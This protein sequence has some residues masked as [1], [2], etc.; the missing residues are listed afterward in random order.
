LNRLI[1][2]DSDLLRQA[3]IGRLQPKRVETAPPIYTYTND[4][5]WQPKTV[6]GQI[7]AEL[8]IQVYDCR[9]QPSVTLPDAIEKF[10]SILADRKE[11]FSKKITLCVDP[12]VDA[13]YESS[14]S[15]YE[16]SDSPYESSDSPYES[17][18]SPYE[19]SDSPYE[20]SDSPYESSD[21]P[22]AVDPSI[23]SN[24]LA[25]QLALERIGFNWLQQARSDLN[26]A[27]VTVLILDTLPV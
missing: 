21:S 5:T 17:S 13:P 18:D 2:R 7:D 14:D 12:T 24:T 15:P 20:S 3:G 9:L 11:E 4:N 23:A 26:G 8:S 16:S 6:S 1:R 19:S 22:M 27:D 10:K 25:G